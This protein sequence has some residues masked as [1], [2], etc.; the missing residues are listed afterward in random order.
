[1]F[2]QV[3][4]SNAGH[5][6]EIVLWQTQV[7]FL[8]RPKQV[9][10]GSRKD[11]WSEFL[12]CCRNIQLQSGNVWGLNAKVHSVTKHYVF[13]WL[14]QSSLACKFQHK[15][16]H[17]LECVFQQQQQHLIN[18]YM[19]C[20]CVYD[21]GYGCSDHY[22]ES[23]TLLHSFQVL[24]ELLKSPTCTDIICDV[25]MYAAHQFLQ[26][27]WFAWEPITIVMMLQGYASQG[28]MTVAHFT[29]Y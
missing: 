12:P 7:W 6:S 26:I 9:I 3:T 29:S 8:M 22:L 27:I 19:L 5:L 17:F 24:A 28:V 10:E 13:V 21:S 14:M 16:S 2:L 23:D 20:A 25:G 4:H 1:L 11:I 18:C 15:L